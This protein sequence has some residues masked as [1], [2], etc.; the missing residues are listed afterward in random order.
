M[1]S[2]I[3]HCLSTQYWRYLWCACI[4]TSCCRDIFQVYTETEAAA[5]NSSSWEHCCRVNGQLKLDRNVKVLP[6]TKKSLK[7]KSE[8][9]HS[10][11]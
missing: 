2:T 6:E 5:L 10:S 7:L 4:C 3:F 11:P 1:K 9:F 8:Y